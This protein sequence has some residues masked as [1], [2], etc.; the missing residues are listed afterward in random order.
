MGV[1]VVVGGRGHWWGVRTLVGGR[2]HCAG[3][4]QW[5]GFGGS[6]RSLNLL[7]YNHAVHWIPISSIEFQIL[8]K[9]SW[10]NIADP[11]P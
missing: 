6:G 5:W 2:A 8:F 4:G 11:V 10:E 1:G 9:V 7:F 3:R